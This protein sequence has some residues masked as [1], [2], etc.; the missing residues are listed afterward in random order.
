[1]NKALPIIGVL[2]GIVTTGL[3]SGPALA[4][5]PDDNCYTMMQQFVAV[6][7][8]LNRTST[9]ASTSTT[10]ALGD[11]L[12]FDDPLQSRVTLGCGKDGIMDVNINWDGSAN[13]SELWYGLAAKL[14]SLT[15]RA[16]KKAV[17]A[18]LRRCIQQALRNTSE[19][20]DVQAPKI[21]VDCQAFARDGGGVSA[22]IYTPDHPRIEP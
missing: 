8:R 10:S 15:T 17:E 11:T 9:T 21:R 12:F 7:L 18:T 3:F 14:G 20:A 19:L 2:F 4:E 22:D 6:G 13:P 16:N 5:E 1:M